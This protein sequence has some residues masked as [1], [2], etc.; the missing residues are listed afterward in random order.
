MDRREVSFIV[1]TNYGTGMFKRAFPLPVVRAI[2]VAAGVVALL[3]AAALVLAGVNAHRLTRLA[4]LERRNR[5]LEVEFGR[6]SQV[7][8]R[9][10]ELEEQSARMAEML[11]VELTPPPVEWGG[12]SQSET[13]GVAYG[14]RP[15]PSFLPLE[16]YVISRGFGVGHPGLDLAAPA[17]TPVYS[18]ADG[19]VVEAGTDSVFG[20]FVLIR[21]EQGYETYYA[22]LLGWRVEAA[23]TVGAGRQVGTVGSTGRSTAPHLHFE[24]WQN[25]E[26]KQIALDPEKELKNLLKPRN[27]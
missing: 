20:R 13:L 4:W 1:T 15:T 27:K 6:L 23:D 25:K 19:V 3:A 10:V 26:G 11:G 18:A 17:G 22:H 14:T 7:H 9:V 5:E 24:L 21:H 2:L 12:A 16:D 8:Q